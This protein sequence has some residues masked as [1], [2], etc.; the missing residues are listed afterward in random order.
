MKKLIA[1]ILPILLSTITVASAW[2]ITQKD[3]QTFLSCNPS[4]SKDTYYYIPSNSSNSITI[5]PD[6]TYRNTQNAFI[7]K[8]NSS[9]DVYRH[10]IISQCE[11]WDRMSNMVRW[12]SI[13]PS[14]QYPALIFKN[15]DGCTLGKP[16]YTKNSN[17]TAIDAQIHYTVA[18]NLFANGAWNGKDKNT[19][20]FYYKDKS[21][22]KF[23]CYPWWNAVE[24][25]SN[26][27]QST[28]YYWKEVDYHTWECLNYRVFW[29]GDG[30]L[31]WRDKN[32]NTITTYDNW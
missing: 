10:W 15:I 19:W 27:A 32:G 17:P 12:W 29:C 28:A 7:N 1:G 4:E 13:N 18:F 30:L 3:V 8:S 24:D 25:N 31:N 16:S 23:M 2:I 6:D 21:T 14:P 5:Y 11:D 9:V 20:K 26:C 22:G